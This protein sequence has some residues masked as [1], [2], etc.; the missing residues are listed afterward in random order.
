MDEKKAQKTRV[1][2]IVYMT[3][4]EKRQLKMFAAETGRTVTEIASQA[5]LATINAAQ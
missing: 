4:A 1:Q 3:P 2:V 5:I